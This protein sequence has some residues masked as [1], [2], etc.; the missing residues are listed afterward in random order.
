M[1][2][3]SPSPIRLFIIVPTLDSYATLPALVDSLSNQSWTNWR[4]LFVDGSSSPE[5]RQWLSS[6]CESDRRY[7]WIKQDQKDPGIFGAMNLGFSV[8]E[9]DDW[10]IFW[11]SDDFAS[12]PSAFLSVVS[13]IENSKFRP[14]LLVCR[15]RYIKSLN[16]RLSRAA[17]FTPQR[18]FPPSS[19][20]SC[21][22]W[23]STPPHQATLFGPGS[24]KLLRRF[25]PGYRLS[26]DL[27]YFLQLSSFKE[28]RVQ[29]TDLELVHM[30]DGGISAQQTRRR[31][32][33]VCYAYRSAFGGYWWFPFLLRYLRR[34]TT[35]FE[36]FRQ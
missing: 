1:N 18:F 14:D 19:F 25:A 3:Q 35:S 21:L 12:K 2:C 34:M 29:C 17:T 27:D 4:V 6:C 15:G 30:L 31:L 23:G 24:R 7:R 22:F 9:P 28:L 33:E 36:C 26:A 5:H 13:I 11:G 8:A 16:G 32:Q 20:R 10:V